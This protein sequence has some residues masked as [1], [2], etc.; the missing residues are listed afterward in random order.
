MYAPIT[1]PYLRFHE[2]ANP[3]RAVELIKLIN[4]S[5]NS[6]NT[7]DQY[8]VTI[9]VG[10]NK[11]DGLSPTAPPPMGN[12]IDI[13]LGDSKHNPTAVGKATVIRC[14]KTIWRYFGIIRPRSQDPDF[15]QNLDG[16]NP[17]EIEHYL[18][19]YYANYSPAVVPITSGAEIS[20]IYLAF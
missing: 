19:I 14:I 5:N 10:F 6:N 9:R 3:K 4:K 20:I 11:C 16:G 8:H 7:L 13:F 2:T 17:Q 1:M 12:R 15:S 18:N